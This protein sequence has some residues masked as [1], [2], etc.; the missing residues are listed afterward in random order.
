[1]MFNIIREMKI[2]TT[3]RYQYTSIRMANTKIVKT[4]KADKDANCIAHK[5]LDRTGIVV[6]PL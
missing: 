5:L 1:M 4:P 3:L 6:Q 2:K